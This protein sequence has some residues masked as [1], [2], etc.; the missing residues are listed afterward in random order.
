MALVISSALIAASTIG[1]L[2]VDL[3]KNTP[4]R[5]YAL[6]GLLVFGILYLLFAIKNM[7]AQ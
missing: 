1:M 7:S 5:F 6:I 3:R 4:N 2:N